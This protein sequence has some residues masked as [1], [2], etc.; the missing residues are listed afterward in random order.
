MC[1]LIR[2]WSK[3]RSQ[4]C[5]GRKEKGP[6]FGLHGQRQR[7]ARS[8]QHHRARKPTVLYYHSCPLQICGLRC[9][10]DTI[11]CAVRPHRIGTVCIMVCICEKLLFPILYS[12][13][14]FSDSC[15][16]P[17]GGFVSLGTGAFP[18]ASSSLSSSSSPDSTVSSCLSSGE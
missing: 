17:A 4:L 7:H 9:K 3:G 16:S 5:T 15:G 12:S 13:S 1:S 11:S 8:N 6:D 10:L 18:F 2:L 14:F